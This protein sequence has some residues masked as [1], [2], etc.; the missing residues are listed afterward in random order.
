VPLIT[1]WLVVALPLASVVLVVGL[2]QSIGKLQIHN[3]LA[4]TGDF[5]GRLIDLVY[6]PIALTRRFVR[7]D[8]ISK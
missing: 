2:M 8:R 4:F 5:A 7:R 1:G 3:V 6:P